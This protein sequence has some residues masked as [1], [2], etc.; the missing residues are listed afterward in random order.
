MGRQ[1]KLGPPTHKGLVRHKHTHRGV[2]V[3]LQE[4]VLYWVTATRVQYRKTD[5]RPKGCGP[6][7]SWVLDLLTVERL[8]Q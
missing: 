4:S 5:G 7:P 2:S 6:D 8:T 1:I 3:R